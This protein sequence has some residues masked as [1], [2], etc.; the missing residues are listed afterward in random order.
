MA[1][2]ILKDVVA[3]VE[4]WSSNGTENYSKTFTTQLVDMGAKMQDSWSTH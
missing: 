4:V 1:A 3:Y 2:P